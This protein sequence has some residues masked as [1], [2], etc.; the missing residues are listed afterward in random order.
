[1]SNTPA[2]GLALH[3][4]G[5]PTAPALLEDRRSPR[6][7]TE[8]VWDGRRRLTAAPWWLTDSSGVTGSTAR[9]AMLR[10]RRS[11][12]FPAWLRPPPSTSVT[13]PPSARGLSTRS[14][15]SADATAS[16]PTP[17][18]STR[19]TA[20]RA[21]PNSNGAGTWRPTCTARSGL[22]RRHSRRSLHRV[23][24]AS[25]GIVSFLLSPAA[26]Y[27][28]GAVLRVDGGLGLSLW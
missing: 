4:H 18:S 3:V 25:S 14:R 23:T 16:W 15:G 17:V 7:R 8:E 6:R 9:P 19:S 21:S 11:T 5:T 24:V 22:H 12:A 13:Q 27:M 2:G 28:N 20:P 1:M 26:A 10:V